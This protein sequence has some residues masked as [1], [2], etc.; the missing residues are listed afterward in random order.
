MP[1]LENLIEFASFISYARTDERSATRLQQALET[2]RLPRGFEHI[3]RGALTPVFRDQ[4]DFAASISLSEAI[5]NALAGSRALIVLCSPAAKASK[6]VN[7]EIETFRRLYP[8][9]PILAALLEGTPQTSFPPALLAKGD[10][11]LAADLNGDKDQWRFGVRQIIAA[12]A[13]VSLN[14]LLDRDTKRRRR[15]F[16]FGLGLA[17]AFSASMALIAA[18]AVSAQ[19]AA[20]ASRSEAEGLVEFMLTDLKDELEPIHRLDLFVDLGDEITAYYKR[21]P[22]RYLKNDRK[23]RWAKAHHLLAQVALDMSDYERAAAEIEAALAISSRFYAER[24]G[25]IDAIFL[26]AQSLFWRGEYARSV[27]DLQRAQADWMAYRDLSVALVE[28]D[29]A[30]ISWLMEQAWSE[31]NL[32]V[33]D[34]GEGDI[35]GAAAGYQLARA[36]FESA[37]SADPENALPKRELANL[38][39]WQA[40]LELKRGTLQSVLSFRRDQVSVLKSL[41]ALD[42]SDRRIASL[43]IVPE[44]EILILTHLSTG[45][46]DEAAWAA[47][48]AKLKGLHDF[49]SNNSLLHREAC[50]ALAYPRLMLLLADQPLGDWQNA[51][52][53]LMIC[54]TIIEEKPTVSPAMRLIADSLT[55]DVNGRLMLNQKRLAVPTEVIMAVG[56]QEKLF[57]WYLNLR[58]LELLGDDGRV[59]S[60]ARA[61]INQ[62]EREI[63]ARSPQ[64]L[65]SLFAAQRAL[66][67][68]SQAKNTLEDLKTRGYVY[69]FGETE[70]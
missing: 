51:S 17:G 46:L 59:A 37:E 31:M 10:E 57:T 36:I 26:H 53:D 60:L 66:A 49:D 7:L 2:Y 1:C 30:N 13:G 45:I 5:R 21:Q 8:E 48:A 35:E 25:S 9:R 16:L 70:C 65:L 14:K 29:P 3:D 69:P 15:R 32:V 19:R 54:Q 64:H 11:P 63:E 41:Q 33:L 44:R 38:L 67:Q 23:V 39:G 62:S 20:E 27:G 4:T 52:N 40:D 56:E 61:I 22:K 34:V 6:W 68:C 18:F 50:L 42:Q 43:M 47:H 55:S 58:V 28:T 12:L 24:P